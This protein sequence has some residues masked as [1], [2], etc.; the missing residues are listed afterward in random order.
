MGKTPKQY[1][2]KFHNIPSGLILA[3]E[4]ILSVVNT[5]NL[6]YGDNTIPLNPG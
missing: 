5:F 4:V 6:R 3:V 2:S 1:W